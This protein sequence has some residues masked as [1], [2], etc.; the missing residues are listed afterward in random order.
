[1]NRIDSLVIAAYLVAVTGLGLAVRLRLGGKPADFHLAGRTLRWFPVGFSVA[2][3][4]FSA[5]NFMAFSGEVAQYG[6]YV[7]MALPAFPLIAI[8]VMRHVIP[9]FHAHRSASAYAFLEQRFNSA[10]RRLASAL[11]V[12]WRL[13]WVAIVLYATARFLAGITGL[14]VV[15]LILLAGVIAILYT[16]LGGFHA[17]VWTDILQFFVL[18]GGLLLAI[19]IAL[20]RIGGVRALFSLAADQGALQPFVPFD[21]ALFSPDPRVR[22]TLWSALIGTLT[23]FLTRYGADQMVVQRYMA[24]RSVRDAQKGFALNIVLALLALVGLVFVGLLARVAGIA[25]GTALPDGAS[26]VARLI[27]FVQALPSGVRGLLVA[28][29]FAS[30][31]SSVDSGLHS[32]VTALTTDVPALRKT[33]PWLMTLLIGVPAVIAACFAGQLGTIFEIANK[34]VNGLGAPL[35]AIV[36]A[37]WFPGRMTARGVLRGGIV[38]TVASVAIVIFVPNMALHYYA[39]VNT[40]LVLALCRLFSG[41]HG[42]RPSS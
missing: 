33:R 13:A 10:V 40:L 1:M 32:C 35:L 31:M 26:G 23:A 42:G 4:L 2:A 41:R 7:I 15:A 22:I 12:L 16:A 37:G 5:I 11:F 18:C 21:S 17:V 6:L 19:V 38:G 3:T 39:V 20:D 29:L 34:A 27:R 9:F 14:P 28:G 30:T 25:D 8:P 24:A 36:V